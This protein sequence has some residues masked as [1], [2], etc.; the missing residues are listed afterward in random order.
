MLIVWEKTEPKEHKLQQ[1]SQTKGDFFCLNMAEQ[2]KP[3][4]EKLALDA[5]RTALY[6]INNAVQKADPNV[7]KTIPKFHNYQDV[8]SLAG[9]PPETHL[10]GKA[11]D[12]EAGRLLSGW[13]ATKFGN[14]IAR[15]GEHVVSDTEYQ[16]FL[17]LSG[18]DEKRKKEDE[19]KKQQD[20]EF[21]KRMR[22]RAVVYES[23]LYR[24]TP[25]TLEQ[26]LQGKT[27]LQRQE[28]T[29]PPA[30]KKKGKPVKIVG[31]PMKREAATE[32]T[33]V[34]FEEDAA[35]KLLDGRLLNKDGELVAFLYAKDSSKK[36]SPVSSDAQVRLDE[37]KAKR[38]RMKARVNL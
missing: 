22:K 9:T 1:I 7:A 21:A 17:R 23:G 26:V 20:D 6:G 12:F 30:T 34:K 13:F 37:M 36:S 19:A 16:E 33:R 5:V 3:T 8:A 15:E 27:T 24:G 14:R 35:V 31:N 2:F 4:E 11:S 28:T 29:I 38:N 18:A 25:W 32:T 10:N